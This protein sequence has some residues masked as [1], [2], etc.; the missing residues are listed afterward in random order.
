MSNKQSL[1]YPAAWNIVFRERSSRPWKQSLRT[2]DDYGL[3]Y[4]WSVIICHC[5]TER[6]RYGVVIPSCWIYTIAW[7]CTVQRRFDRKEISRTVLMFWTSIFF[8]IS[9]WRSETAVFSV[10]FTARWPISS[11]KKS[12]WWRTD[13][14]WVVLKTRLKQSYIQIRNTTS[15]R[16][17]VRRATDKNK[18]FSWEIDNFDWHPPLL[19]DKGTIMII[20]S[21]FFSFFPLRI[22]L[23][24]W[25]A[26]RIY[27]HDQF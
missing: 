14:W 8:L 20:G 11:A 25:L 19:C 22:V 18:Y 7:F 10:A 27:F 24:V 4:W 23:S 9:Q 21:L 5:Q 1:C 15:L 13:W 16:R 6:R 17:Q 26:F 3:F 2:D 12:N